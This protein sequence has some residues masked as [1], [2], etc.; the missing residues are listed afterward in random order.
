MLLFSSLTGHALTTDYATPGAIQQNTWDMI[1]DWLSAGL[2]PEECTLFIQSDIKEHAELYLLLGMITPLPWLE[3]NPTYK[4][5]LVQL[6]QKDVAT[7]GFLGY[8]VLQAARY[9]H[10]QGPRGSGGKKTS[11]PMWN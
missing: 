10:I 8:P 7:Y 11:C 2:N 5:Q 4:E 1:L 6:E 9:H 3:R